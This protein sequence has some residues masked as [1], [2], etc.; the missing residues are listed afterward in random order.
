M[1]HKI[2][3]L[4]FKLRNRFVRNS[5]QKHLFLTA[6]NHNF[7]KQLTLL[8]TTI[9][10]FEDDLIIIY[11][12]GLIE[13]DII[14]LKANFENIEIVLFDFSFMSFDCN[15]KFTPYFFILVCS[16]FLTI[17]CFV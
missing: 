6:A 9:R 12:I 16:I 4:L 7:I 2:V 3:S 1:K 13:N 17:F 11:D 15:V 5:K 10:K 8:I 14:Q